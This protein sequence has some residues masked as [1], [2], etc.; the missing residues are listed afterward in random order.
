[1][2]KTERKSTLRIHHA[3][4]WPGYN[5]ETYVF[6][7]IL[8][9]KFKV[10]LDAQNPDFLFY[11]CFGKEHQKYDCVRICFLG[12][13]VTPDFNWC[14]YAMGFDHLNLGDRYLR[15]PLYRLSISSQNMCGLSQ[16]EAEAVFLRSG[17]CNFLYSNVD[18]DPVR[19]QI[20]DA[21]C[22]YKPVDSGGKCRNTLG[23][24]VKDGHAWQKGYKFSIAC[25]NSTKSGYTTEKLL[26]ALAADTIPIYWGNPEVAKDFNPAFP[27][28]T[29]LFLA[30]RIGGSCACFG[31]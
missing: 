15:Y 8:R 11:S 20:F 10:I 16:H 4:F 31:K 5:P 25:E 1:M 9:R 26:C 27:S 30:G 2:P 24:R 6:T 13:N 28:S 22:A 23:H 19:E 18:A 29:R 14:D 7:R 12:E 17:F 21:L 3:D